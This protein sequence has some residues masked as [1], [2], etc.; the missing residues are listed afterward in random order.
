SSPIATTRPT[1]SCPSTTPRWQ[2]TGPWSHSEASVPQIAARITWSTTSLAPG[3]GGSATFSIRTSRGPWKTAALT[4]SALD[5]NLHVASGVAGSIERTRGIVE[6][7]SR[8]K[9]RRRVDP[10]RRHETNRARPQPR[11]SDDPSHLQRL[12]L[13]EADFR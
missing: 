7:E 13:D 4:A 3:G 6:R 12:R 1:N 5:L 10:A 8:G 11:R 2:R 9:Q